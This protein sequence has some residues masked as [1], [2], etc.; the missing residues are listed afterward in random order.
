MKIL[1]SWMKVGFVLLRQRVS[2]VATK[3]AIEMSELCRNRYKGNT[4]YKTQ[5]AQAQKA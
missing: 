5:L 4:A 2:T 3:V 1:L